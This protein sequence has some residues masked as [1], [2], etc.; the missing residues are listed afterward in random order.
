MDEMG[1]HEHGKGTVRTVVRA[2]R[3]ALKTRVWPPI[4]R[5]ARNRQNCDQA[6][7]AALKTRVWPRRVAP[8]HEASGEPTKLTK[9]RSGGSP[10]GRRQGLSDAS[11]G[12][13]RDR[14]CRPV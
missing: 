14:A 13:R 10:P 11:G 2:L 4:M 6:L 8:N 3:A 9:P 1:L 7:R 12:T 5:P